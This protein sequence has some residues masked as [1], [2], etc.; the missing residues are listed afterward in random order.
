MA[1]MSTIIDIMSTIIDNISIRQKFGETL[2]SI[3]SKINDRKARILP[4]LLEDLYRG[5]MK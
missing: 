3:Y 1:I 2:L 5:T 4:A